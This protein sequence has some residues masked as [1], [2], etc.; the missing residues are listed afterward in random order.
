MV[1][2]D[3]YLNLLAA[4]DPISLSGQVLRVVGLS[5]VASGPAVPVGDLCRVHSREGEQLALVVGFR[6]GELLLRPLGPSPASAPA[7]ASTTGRGLRSRSVRPGRPRHRRPRPAARRQ[8]AHP[9]P[10]RRGVTG[11]PPAA[12]RPIADVLETGFKIVDTLFTLGKGQRMGIFAGSGVGKSVLLEMARHARADINVIALVGER[13]R[14][15]GEFDKVSA[16]G[17]ALSVVI[18]ATSDRRRSSARRRP[19]RPQRRRELPR[20]RS[21]RAL[22][23]GFHHPPVP[24]WREIGLSAGEPPTV[25]GYPPSAF[26][27]LPP[28]L[29]RAGTAEHLDHRPLHGAHRQRRRER[30]GRRQRACHPRRPLFLSRQRPVAIFR[31]SRPSRSAVDGRPGQRADYGL[32][33]RARELWGDSERVRDL[34]GAYQQGADPQVDLALERQPHLLALSSRAWAS[35][36][37]PN[38]SS[39]SPRR[40]APQPSSSAEMAAAGVCMSKSKYPQLIAHVKKQEDEQRAR[41]VE[42]AQAIDGVE[43]RLLAYD[44]EQAKAAAHH[45]PVDREQFFTYCRH[46]DGKRAQARSQ[47]ELRLRQGERT[48]LM[49]IHRRRRSFEHLL[50]REEQRQ[51]ERAE[52]RMAKADELALR[53]WTEANAS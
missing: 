29:E 52:R 10:G 44:R 11:D 38:P 22:D 30:S 40:S 42:V 46:L 21:R 12:R 17:L 25:R 35:T 18:V 16:E 15:V 48:E 49:A 2:L 28:L 1:A 33:M 47:L 37:A 7:T 31:P 6:E 9:R 50:T 51:A 3:K 39:C 23:D 24:R 4:S 8:G 20:C 19:G 14:E 45:R 5:V 43:G 41:L 34:V 26:A 13:G 27:L 53:R 32:A 36:A